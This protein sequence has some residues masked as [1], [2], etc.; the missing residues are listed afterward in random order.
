MP[1]AP[2][3]PIKTARDAFSLM[4]L[5]AVV[6]ILGLLAALAL[7]RTES[8]RTSGLRAA[9][10]VNRSEVEVQAML[11]KR[12]NG[13]WPATNLSDIGASATYFPEGAPNCPV[14]GATYTI[15]STGHVVG[16]SH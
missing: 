4:E 1:K 13:A 12:A 10:H 11:W 7:P 9:C 3:T 15:D 2:S 14:D 16:H 5:M 8:V 6:A